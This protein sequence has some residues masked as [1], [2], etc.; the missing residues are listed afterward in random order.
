MRFVA[1]PPARLTFVVEGVVKGLTY[2]A[3][4]RLIW[5]PQDSQYR[6]RQEISAFLLGER[7][8]SSTGALTPEELQPT[9]F[10]DRQRKKL[11]AA[12]LDWPAGLAHFEPSA[13]SAPIGAGTQDRL[14]VFLQLA[15]MVAAAP[16]RFVAGTTITVPTASS[17]TVELWHFVVQQPQPLPLP[18]DTL[19][20]LLLERLP[21]AG[22]EQKAQLWL[23]PA[24]GYLPVRIRLSEPS[25][26]YVD[27]Q[28]HSHA[29]P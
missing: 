25:G 17:K 7:S 20:T 24:L 22:H 21:R 5:Q 15:G 28:L 29:T 14:S 23:A 13:T 11:R 18:A 10:E 4:A 16:A 8:Q 6:A 27:L 19:E 3:R 9:R 12:T 26:D 1:P 2:H